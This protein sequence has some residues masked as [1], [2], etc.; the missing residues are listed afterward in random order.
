MA[1]NIEPS[2]EEQVRE[3]YTLVFAGMRERGKT[4][5]WT[6]EF[7]EYFLEKE[8]KSEQKIIKQRILSEVTDEFGTP[9]AME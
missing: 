2:F 1:V 5:K 7:M 4:P 3:L 9:L 6:R 8:P